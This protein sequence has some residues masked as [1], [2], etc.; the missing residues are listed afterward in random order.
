MLHCSIDHV[1]PQESGKKK[2]SEKA[3]PKKKYLAVKKKTSVKI[4]Y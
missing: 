4:D 2:A 1:S 3:K